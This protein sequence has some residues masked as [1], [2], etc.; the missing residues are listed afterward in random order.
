PFYPYTT[1][2]RSIYDDYLSVDKNYIV[3]KG[4]WIGAMVVTATI[5]RSSSSSSESWRTKFTQ[6]K[7]PHLGSRTI[8]YYSGLS[9]NLDSARIDYWVYAGKSTKYAIEGAERYISGSSFTAG[10]LELIKI[11]IMPENLGGSI[12]NWESSLLNADRGVTYQVSLLVDGVQ[13]RSYKVSGKGPMFPWE[14]GVDYV[15]FVWDLNIPSGA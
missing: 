5:R 6:Y 7:V 2:F 10:T 13:K 8:K 1:L 12:L 9:A 14:S 3:A 4:T 11:F 15:K